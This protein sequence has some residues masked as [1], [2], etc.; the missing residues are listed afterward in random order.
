[1]YSSC[2]RSMRPAPG[3][4]R[5]RREEVVGLSTVTNAASRYLGAMTT[6]F[7]QLSQHGQARRLRPLAI[8]ALGAYDPEWTRLRLL[9]NEWNCTFRVDGPAGPR[10]L[11]IMRRDTDQATTKVGSEDEFTS[12]LHAATDIAPPSIIRSRDGD[13]FVIASADGVPDARACVLFEWLPGSMLGDRISV[14]R[15]AAL[16]ELVARMHRFASTF[17]PSPKFHAVTYASALAYDE[18]LVLFDSDRVDLLGLDSLLREATDITNE[19]V[20]TIMREQPHIVIHG[21]L[22]GWN[23]KLDRGVLTPFD[24][25]DLLW[26]APILDVA[27][28]LFYIRDRPDYI[29]LARS[30]KVGYERHQPWVEERPGQVDELIIARG[31]D[32][33]NFVALDPALD[34]PDMDAYVRRREV[35]ALVAVGARDPI[36]L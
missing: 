16:G 24:W 32:M 13:P 9:S 26:G 30:F 27:T 29:D 33:L 8:E 35:P 19:R 1:M 2:L 5:A 12:A 11:R 3:V 25:E 36:E 7:D 18:P 17:S 10:A 28:S 4:R 6:P 34:I 22:H 21:D 14:E 15:W 20:A 31:I 23:I